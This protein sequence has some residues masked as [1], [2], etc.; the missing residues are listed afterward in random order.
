VEKSPESIRQMFPRYTVYVDFITITIQFL[1]KNK[2]ALLS[3][4]SL[5]EGRE[6]NETTV[7]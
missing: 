6:V 3:Y 1:I 4:C 2:E 5:Y 7:S